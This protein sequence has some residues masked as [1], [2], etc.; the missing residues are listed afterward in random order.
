[1]VTKEGFGSVV[2]N[3]STPGSEDETSIL[4]LSESLQLN[5]FDH[6][7]IGPEDLLDLSE[8]LA[9]TSIYDSIVRGLVPRPS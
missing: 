1:M 2:G 5:E 3:P 6:C 9:S 4:L 7:K 8:V